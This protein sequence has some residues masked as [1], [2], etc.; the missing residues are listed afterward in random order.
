[1]IATLDTMV[2]ESRCLA[3]AEACKE[4]TTAYHPGGHFVPIGKGMAGILVGF[5]RG[6]CEVKKEGVEERVEDMDVPF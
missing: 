3:L 4:G 6:C 2:E 5:V 1:V